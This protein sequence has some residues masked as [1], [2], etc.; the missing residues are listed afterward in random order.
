MFF[1]PFYVLETQFG[2]DNF[3]VAKRVHVALDVDDLGIVKSA[4]DLE[5]AIDGADV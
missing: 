5:D 4:H 2:L 3:H 1:D